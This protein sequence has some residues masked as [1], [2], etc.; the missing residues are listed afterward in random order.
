M[1]HLEIILICDS[2][3]I[4]LSLDLSVLILETDLSTSQVSK[5]TI[6]RDSLKLESL[7][8]SF[9]FTCLSYQQALMIP[10]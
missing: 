8:Q 7:T 3:M 2:F 5:I 6:E 1:Y 10:R 9:I 4:S